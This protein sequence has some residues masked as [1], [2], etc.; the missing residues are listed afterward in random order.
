[1][2]DASGNPFVIA[3]ECPRCGAPLDLGESTRAVSCAHCRSNLLVTGRRE[4]LS[5]RIAPRVSAAE[6]IS[7]C[8]FADAAAGNDAQRS[9]PVL[10]LVPYYRLT[11][12]ELRW[13]PAPP[14]HE[15]DPELGD[16]VEDFNLQLARLAL[17]LARAEERSGPEDV[18]IAAR[19]LE[20]NFVAC[21]L[22]GLGMY[23][24]GV[25]PSVLR[26]ELFHHDGREAGER[27]E[28]YATRVVPVTLPPA[29]ARERALRGEV[30]GETLY[31]E[32]LGCT[33]SIIYSPF[34][35]IETRRQG[36]TRRALQDA[37]SGTLMPRGAGD[38]LAAKVDRP[39]AAETRTLGFQALAC[40]NCGWD[41]P[42]DP[43]AAVFPCG[44]CGRAWQSE[45][46]RLVEVGV[47]I[48]DLLEKRRAA[49]L[50]YLPVW[51]VDFASPTGER[52]R[53]VAPAFHCRGL[54]QVGELGVRLSRSPAALER[55]SAT[56]SGNETLATCALDREDGA[57]LARFVAAG[58]GY[59]G[60]PAF[61]DLDPHSLAVKDTRLIWL[62]FAPD[63]Y[64]LCEPASGAS[65]PQNLIS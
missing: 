51:R 5:Y 52:L 53:T 23:S 28:P 4:A 58:L 48:A 56:R 57:A 3:T 65:V 29:A 34:W 43:S 46:A 61:S 37:V 62:P 63:G 7:L 31:R 24:L 47:E 41:L 16:L 60:E 42:V 14:P 8:R 54:R 49:N 20:K 44:S 2:S 18:A 27:S 13:T 40:P 12:S 30:A 39:P 1:V 36:E 45:E 19:A 22:D 21:E 33:L 17:T 10:C 15:T 55:T 59:R 9:E 32:L 25:R 64:S 35:L 50:R 11:G 26:L 6:A 38:E